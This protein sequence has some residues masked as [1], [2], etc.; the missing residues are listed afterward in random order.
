MFNFLP[1]FTLYSFPL[2]EVGGCHERIHL[3][4]SKVLLCYNFTSQHTLTAKKFSIII[5][6]QTKLNRED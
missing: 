3:I 4:D 5:N 1:S 6:L 2:F